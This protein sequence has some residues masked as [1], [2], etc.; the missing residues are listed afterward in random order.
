LRK[1]KP[2]LVYVLDPVLGDAGRLY[3]NPDVVPIYRS[4]LPLATVITPNWFE[5]EVLTNVELRDIASLRRALEILHKQHHV[6]NVVI[7]SIPLRPWLHDALPSN[8]QP[9]PDDDSDY[10]LCISSSSSPQTQDLSAVHAQRVPLLP[11][12]FS[13]VGDIF[14]ALLMAHFQSPSGPAVQDTSTPVSHAAS[15]AL[16]KTHA[17]LEL[18]YEHA[19]SLPEN[20]RLP[21][22]E[23]KD[24]AEPIRKTR[25]MR[26]RELRLVQ[27]QDIIRGGFTQLRRLEPW[28]GFWNT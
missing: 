21:T 12:Y 28:V 20:E 13:G 17:I 11:G 5:V 7:S 19:Q 27:G 9:P 10:L 6:L 2:Q 3:V 18:T 25:R 23:E 4:M 24:A 14:S 26:G 16:T 22:D 8:I 1:E 15:F